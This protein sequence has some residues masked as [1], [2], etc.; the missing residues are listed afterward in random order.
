MDGQLQR[1]NQPGTLSTISDKCK[2]IAKVVVDVN[3]LI[4]FPL[5]V[6]DVVVWS[7]ELERML[8]DSELH[9]LKFMFDCF[10]REELIWD[11]TKGIQNIFSGLK[12]IGKNE[13]GY[14]LKKQIW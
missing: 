4:P 14:Y 3:L 8:P 12:M 10:K 2:R 13:E 9:K 1:R 7:A 6:D 5:P 11:K